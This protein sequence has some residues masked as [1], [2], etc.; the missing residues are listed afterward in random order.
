MIIQNKNLIKKLI[1]HNGSFHA[2]DLFACAVLFLL[3]EKR[4]EKFEIIRTR[5][6]NILKNGD[7]VFDVGGIYDV[8]NKLHFSNKYARLDISDFGCEHRWL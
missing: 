6:E 1:T 4:G 5:D 2:D 3:L 8:E 7:Y